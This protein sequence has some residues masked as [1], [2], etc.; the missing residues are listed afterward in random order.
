MNAT[1]FNKHTLS[2]G[3]FDNKAGI[4][5]I[6]YKYNISNDLKN[7][8]FIGIGTALL[9]Y[10]ASIG[11]E[12]TYKKSKLWTSSIILSEQ[13]IAHLG[14]TGLFSNLS[15]SSSI[16]LTNYL[17]FKLGINGAIGYRLDQPGF[18]AFAYPFTGLDFNF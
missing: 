1:D 14:F 17:D 2:I 15:L 4:S 6:S 7:D 10:T 5:L 13:A 12:H 3:F 8:Y 9:A 18:A 11:W 16:P